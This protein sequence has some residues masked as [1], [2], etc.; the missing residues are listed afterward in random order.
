MIRSTDAIKS[1]TAASADRFFWQMTIL[2]R[3]GN[4]TPDLLVTRNREEVPFAPL[5][6]GVIMDVAV[7]ATVGR[8]G[9]QCADVDLLPAAQRGKFCGTNSGTTVTPDT[10]SKASSSKVPLED[11]GCANL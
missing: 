8:S 4:R 3:G 11:H 10:R 7:N 5:S 9:L 6:Q 1:A 2:S